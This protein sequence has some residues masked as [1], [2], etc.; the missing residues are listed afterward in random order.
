MYAVHIDIAYSMYYVWLY[1]TIK[2]MRHVQCVHCT[3]YTVH[4]TLY[5]LHYTVYKCQRALKIIFNRSNF[6]LFRKKRIK[7]KWSLL[8]KYLI[9]L[10][11]INTYLKTSVLKIHMPRKTCI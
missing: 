2:Y 9:V 5:R 6:I 4:C 7:E 8:Y 1:D 11:N 10:L 3:R